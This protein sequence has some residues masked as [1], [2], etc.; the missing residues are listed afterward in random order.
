MKIKY[1]ISFLVVFTVI[2]GIFFINQG[3]LESVKGADLNI[4]YGGKR[5][6][7]PASQHT[8]YPDACEMDN[9]NWIITYSEGTNSNCGLYCKISTNQAT[10][11]GSAI[12]ILPANNKRA[13][14]TVCITNDGTVIAT[15]RHVGVGVNDA[16]WSISTDNGSTWTDKGEIDMGHAF[17]GFHMRTINGVTYL[18]TA[19][20]NTSDIGHQR[21]YKTLDNG[22]TWT[23]HKACLTDEDWPGE[24]TFIDITN[25]H[26]IAV[27][28]SDY[29]KATYFSETFDAGITWSAYEDLTSQMGRFQSPTL[30]Y[31]NEDEGI[32][33]LSGRVPNVNG[34]EGHVAFW[35]SDDEGQTWKNYT[36]V[37]PYYADCGYT[38]FV[39]KGDYGFLVWFGGTQVTSAVYGCWIY[40]NTSHVADTIPTFLS[41]DSKQNNSLILVNNPTINWTKIDN[42]QYYNLQ[43]STTSDFSTITINITDINESVYPLYYS[44]NSTTVSFIIPPADVLPSNQRYY[45]RV[46]SFV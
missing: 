22:D 2:T 26:W 16:E 46:R 43:I 35:I 9:G 5:T 13:D 32:I 8:S 42:A 4:G 1:L 30:S 25:T 17:A 38:G 23:L 39:E 40:D 7:V 36:E 31:L 24:W 41:V 33:M 18:A 15:N 28:R 10:S 34:P 19:Q 6:V 14:S 3:V 45:M 11:W 44:E 27:F 21:I 12:Q 20:L 29:H 37:S